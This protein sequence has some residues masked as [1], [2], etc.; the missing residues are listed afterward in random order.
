MFCLD[1]LDQLKDKLYF[2]GKNDVMKNRRID[3]NLVACTPIQIT[4][5]N[6]HNNETECLIDL[7]NNTT[8]E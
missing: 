3:I 7:T 5:A 2:Y 4:D 1:K 8:I 6:K